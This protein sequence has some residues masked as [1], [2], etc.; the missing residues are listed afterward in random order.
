MI[1]AVGDYQFA[2]QNGFYGVDFGVYEKWVDR[3]ELEKSGKTKS[4]I[5][6]DNP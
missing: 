6:N 3:D 2:E 4:P 5:R 1:N